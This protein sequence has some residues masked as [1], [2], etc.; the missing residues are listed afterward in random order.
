M[1]ISSRD[2]TMSL[3]NSELRLIKVFSMSLVFEVGTSTWLAFT[4]IYLTDRL[5]SSN[6]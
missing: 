6:A 4:K 3:M 2:V 1:P 5:A